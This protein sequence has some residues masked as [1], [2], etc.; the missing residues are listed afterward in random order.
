M[1][2]SNKQEESKPCTNGVI[3]R[4][5]KDMAEIL[6]DADA[7]NDLQDLINLWNEIANNKKRYP[8]TDI[9][10][11]NKH[12][13][14]LALKTSGQDIDKGKFYHELKSQCDGVS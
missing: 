11:A 12:I 5:F 14:E 3:S 2:K 9:W 6:K 10:N 8:L 7:T 13:R 1:R 4:F